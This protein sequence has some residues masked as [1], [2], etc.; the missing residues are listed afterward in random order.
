MLAEFD[1][2]FIVAVLAEVAV[3]VFEAVLDGMT[4]EAVLDGMTFEEVLDGMTFEAVY[5]SSNNYNT[6]Y[7]Y[8]NNTNSYFARFHSDTTLTSQPPSSSS[9]S[10]STPPTE[11]KNASIHV[12]QRVM[13][14]ERLVM[15][16]K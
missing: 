2:E 8:S 9:E 10:D 15:E 13:K 16:R 11:A 3:N 12:K 14:M 7:E 5:F 4:F 6:W 1:L